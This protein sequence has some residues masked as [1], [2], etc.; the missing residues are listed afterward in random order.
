MAMVKLYRR[1]KRESLRSKMLLQVHDELVFETP[2]EV[3][4]QEAAI[5][6]EE[7]VNAMKLTVP[8]KVEVGWGKTLAGCEITCRMPN[9]RFSPA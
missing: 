5:I 6:R 7:M 2:A 1:M 9:D 3:A 4:E 8:L